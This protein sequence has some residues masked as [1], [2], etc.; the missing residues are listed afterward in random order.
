MSL[1]ALVMMLAGNFFII[2]VCLIGLQAAYFRGRWKWFWLML[3]CVLVSASCMGI[4]LMQWLT[5]ASRDIQVFVRQP[6]TPL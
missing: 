5:P 2:I 1:D 6:T 4:E 3:A